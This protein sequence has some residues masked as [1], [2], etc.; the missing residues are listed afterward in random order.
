MGTQGMGLATLGG[1]S[2]PRITQTRDSLK[3]WHRWLLTDMC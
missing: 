1:Q 2:H 3:V